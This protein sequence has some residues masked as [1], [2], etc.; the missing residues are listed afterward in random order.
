[1]TVLTGLQRQLALGRAAESARRGDLDGA[2]ALLVELDETGEATPEVLD[3]LARIRA[4]QKK[5]SEADGYW[6]RVQE[7]APDD[8]AAA[9]GRKT[10]ASIL[11]HRRA[12]R[13]V[14]PLV[15]VVA[16]V[17]A[18]AVVVGGIA[19]FGGDDQPV[20]QP[21][22]EVQPTATPSVDTSGHQE[23][24]ELARKLAALEAERQA[25]AAAVA[26][27][28]ELI[29]RKVAGPGVVVQRRSG[30]V[31]V[32]FAEGL[33]SAGTEFGPGRQDALVALGKRLP[34]LDAAITVTGYSVVVPGSSTSG[35]SRTALLRA[36]T[37]TQELSAASGLPLT[38]FAMQS[39][40]QG[41]P[42]FRNAAKNRTV[43]LTLTPH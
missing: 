18:V 34:G 30:T 25:S 40:D 10:V 21:T 38:A 19:V 24:A 20:A 27:K 33:F 14:L 16:G 31:R 42:L 7:T 8:A 1:M 12:S 17:A 41:Q 4:Q 36:R 26:N 11:G 3:L 39:G 43:T 9:A 32:L 6:S 29:E 13:P 22:Q 37:A 15:G 28:L 5:W 2:A 35:G 23:A